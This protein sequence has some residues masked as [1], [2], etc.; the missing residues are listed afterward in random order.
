MELDILKPRHSLAHI[1]AQAV[2]RTLDP[3]VKLGI[4]PAIDTGFYYDFI[5]SDSVEFG[6]GNLKDLSKYM[7]KIIKENQDFQF[8]ESTYEESEEILAMLGQEFKL[9]LLQKFKDE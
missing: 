2:Q 8:Y 4:G 7:Q 1:L 9:D 3:Y 5:F 6:E